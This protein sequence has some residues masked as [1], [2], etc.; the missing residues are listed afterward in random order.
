MRV[1]CLYDPYMLLIDVMCIYLK[2]AGF[3]N[4]NGYMIHMFIAGGDVFP[5]VW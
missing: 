1:Q 3:A 4:D 2:K 5:I